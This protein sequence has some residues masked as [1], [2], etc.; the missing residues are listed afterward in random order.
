MN[1]QMKMKPKDKVK[2]VDITGKSQYENRLYR[3]LA[4]APFR[5]YTNRREYIEKGIPIGFH[6]KLLTFNEDI[7]GTIEYSPADVSGFPIEGKGVVVM[8]C[9]WVL[10]RAKGHNFGKRLL[11][12]MRSAEKDTTGFATLAFENHWSPWMK[13]DQMERLG[14]GAIDS[15]KMRHKSRHKDKCFSVFLMW[16]PRTKK[17]DPPVWNTKKLLEGVTFCMGHPLYKPQSSKLKEI[18]EKC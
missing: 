7:V 12:S 2:I 1:I 4:S 14:F 17:A 11:N 10:R 9:I 15:L 5:K 6:K 16:L 18:Y 8:N 3:C 13:K